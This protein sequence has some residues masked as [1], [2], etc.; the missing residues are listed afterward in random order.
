MRYQ[1]PAACVRH[2]WTPTRQPMPTHVVADAGATVHQSPPPSAC[3]PASR[4]QAQQ[5]TLRRL[6][7]P[8]LCLQQ[9]PRRLPNGH[10]KPPSAGVRWS[11][12]VKTTRTTKYFCRPFLKLTNRNYRRSR[13]PCQHQLFLLRHFHHHPCLRLCSLRRHHR[14]C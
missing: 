14:R 1:S 10:E 13:R 8:R 7:R 9:S 3:Q 2:L 6:R 5:P 4:F 11:Y 12:C